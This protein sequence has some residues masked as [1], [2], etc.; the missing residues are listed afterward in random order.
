[1]PC[2][3]CP[4]LLLPVRRSKAVYRQR[5]QSSISVVKVSFDALIVILQVRVFQ[6]VMSPSPCGV[7]KAKQ[8]STGAPVLDAKFLSDDTIVMCGLDRMVHIWNLTSNVLTPL[9]VVSTASLLGRDAVGAMFCIF[10]CHGHD[11]DVWS[12]SRSTTLVCAT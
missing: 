11:V 12:S 8:E 10:H 1:M 4:W 5:V 6:L 9:G 2:R 3:L 7:L